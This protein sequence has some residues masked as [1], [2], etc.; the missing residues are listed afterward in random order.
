MINKVRVVN[1]LGES[2]ELELR[3]PEKSG[4]LVRYIDGLG[5]SKANV[6]M[7]ELSTNDGA[8]YNSARVSSRNIVFNL[9]LLPDDS[10]EDTRQKLYR[11]FPIKKR[12]GI[13]ITTDNRV[14]NTYGYVESNEVDI[15]SKEET[16]TISVM[17]PD[18]YFYS[19]LKTITVLSGVSALFEFPFSNESL[20]ESLIEFDAI[21]ILNAQTM[22]YNGDANVGVMIYIHV[23]G[24]AEM[25]TIYN[26]GTKEEMTIDTD[27]LETLTGTALSEGDEI[28]ISTLTGSKT[29]TLLREGEYINI[30]SC[31][32]K[33]SDWF[34][35]AKGDNIFAFSADTGTDNLQF[36]IENQT[37]YEGV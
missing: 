2:I 17:C 29:V 12:I 21:S 27:R 4:F 14:C 19:T 20:T 1:H 22:V 25:I 9:L 32:G 24:L 36:R 31:V 37:V 18:S 8:V 5:P 6:N 11:Y 3:F 26:T 16:T 30:L 33:N 28:I 34:Q 7:T 35:L 15:F 23:L 13:R 10:I